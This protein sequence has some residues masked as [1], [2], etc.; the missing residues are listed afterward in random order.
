VNLV[1][2]EWLTAPARSASS[3]ARIG[4]WDHRQF[5][6]S[7]PSVN[8]RWLGRTQSSNECSTS[9]AFHLVN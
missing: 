3:P 6:Q 5:Y 8:G 2:I 1:W 4:W 9:D 7:A